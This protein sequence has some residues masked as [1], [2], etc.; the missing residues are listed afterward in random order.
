[1]KEYQGKVTLGKDIQAEQEHF[2][3]SCLNTSSF[4]KH[5]PN[6]LTI[7]RLLGAP[8]CV[9]FIAHNQLTLSFWIF[10]AISITD[11]LDG[12]LAR[13]WQVTSN[14]GQM[15]DPIADKF[16]IM[17]VYL[18]L[19][20]W[21]FI[22]IWLTALVLSRDLLILL[23]SCVIILMRPAKVNLAP[24]LI[25]KISTTAQMLFVGLIL[26]RGGFAPFSPTSS[27]ENILMVSFLYSIALLTVLSGITYARMAMS[28][29]RQP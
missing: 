22:P 15:L 14:F 2:V 10:F 21:T 27:I 1:M 6:T 16:L 4:Y 7:L 29:L 12:Y 23:S 20:W 17:S 26:A 13:R 5:C 25:G 9:W 11:W 24:N 8:L 19:G 18:A 28:T 3:S